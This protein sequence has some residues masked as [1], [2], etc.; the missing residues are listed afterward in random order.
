[1]TLDR[2]PKRLRAGIARYV[3]DGVRPGGFLTAVFENDLFEA[4]G[5]ADPESLTALRDLVIY[6]YNETPSQCWG[7]PAHMQEW[8][9]RGGAHGIMKEG[10][11]RLSLDPP[12]DELIQDALAEDVAGV[13]G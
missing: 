11:R 12:L 13:T 1:M 10:E 5:R 7:S 9:R 4:L 6:V 8:M 2:I 3:K